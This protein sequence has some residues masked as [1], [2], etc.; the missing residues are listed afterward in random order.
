LTKSEAA[1]MTASLTKN[2]SAFYEGF[3]TEFFSAGGE[4]KVTDS[5][6]QT[7]L[8]LCHQADK[9]AALECMA[10]FGFT[11]FRDDLAK[12]DV[13]TL[14]VHGDGDETVPYEGSGKRTH[15]AIPHSQLHVISGAPHGCNVSHAEEWN[16]ALLNFLAQ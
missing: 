10:A 8:S 14:V 9:T 12:F 7:V 16:D 13:T 1:K 5:Q 3:I 2:Q 6:R 15:Q 4:L 11:D